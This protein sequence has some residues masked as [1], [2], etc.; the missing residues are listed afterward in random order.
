MSAAEL[1]ALGLLDPCMIV[2]FE[3]T[4]CDF[5]ELHGETARLQCALADPDRIVIPSA[6]FSVDWP[7][8]PSGATQRNEYRRPEGRWTRQQVLDAL[9]KTIRRFY[10]HSA[11]GTIAVRRL[12]YQVRRGA[13]LPVLESPSG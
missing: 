12:V 8:D 1:A 4:A 6:T 9:R 7:T 11:T 5:V 13:Y 3:S 10:R 2:T